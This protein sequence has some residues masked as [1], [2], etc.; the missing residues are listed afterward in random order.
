MILADHLDAIM[1][2]IGAIGVAIIGGAVTL[3]VQMAKQRGEQQ[4]AR[5][6][7]ATQIARVKAELEP[8]H[9]TSLRDAIDR[10]DARQSATYDR[11]LQVND[12]QDAAIEANRRSLANVGAR[13]G[14]LEQLAALHGWV[15]PAILTGDDGKG[16]A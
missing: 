10:I 6:E 16:E 9:G 4:Q 8:D 7:H 3:I 12:R 15:K 11:L 5:I 13:V 2:A 14:Q 1:A